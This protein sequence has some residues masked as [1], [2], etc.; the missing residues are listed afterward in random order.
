MSELEIMVNS[1]NVIIGKL[2]FY[3]KQLKYNK[4][5]YNNSELNS[6][7]YRLRTDYEKFQYLQSRIEVESDKSVVEKNAM[8]AK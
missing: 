7:L 4:N 1:V 5:V 8:N 2:E 6:I 3:K